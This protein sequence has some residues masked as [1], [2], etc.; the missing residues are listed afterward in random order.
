[1]AASVSGAKTVTVT[2]APHLTAATLTTLL[3]TAVENLTVAQ[4]L[5]I[6]EALQHIPN[7]GTTATLGTL[8][9]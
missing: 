1:M 9:V 5:Q 2:V 8:L 3:A 6:S 4:F 7:K